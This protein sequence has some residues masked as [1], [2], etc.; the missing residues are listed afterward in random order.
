VLKKKKNMS[1]QSASKKN[2][3]WKKDERER[4]LKGTYRTRHKNQKKS[5]GGGKGKE[6]QYC[7]K[8]GETKFKLFLILTPNSGAVTA[9]KKSGLPVHQYCQREKSTKNWCT[10]ISHRERPTPETGEGRNPSVKK[11]AAAKNSKRGKLVNGVGR[12]F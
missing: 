1:R 8:G 10:A 6:G 7:V 3:C 2:I 5:G 11:V 12:K 4:G 9:K